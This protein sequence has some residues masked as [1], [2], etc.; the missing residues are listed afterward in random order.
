MQLLKENKY[1]F[2]M[3]ILLPLFFFCLDNVFIVWMR[4]F[5]ESK[6]SLQLLLESID[7][8]INVISHGVSLIIIACILYVVGK[9]SNKRLYEAGKMLGI[10][11]LTAG[12]VTQILKHLLGRARPRVTE[13]LLFI[14]PTLKSGY[15][16]FPSGHTAVAFCFAYILSAHFPRYR[17][18]F[19]IIA[20]IAGFERAE[21][22][23]HFL[24][25]VLAGALIG[26]IAGKIL[27]KI[28]QKKQFTAN[29]ESVAFPHAETTVNSNE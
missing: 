3:A 1:L 12:I 20:L 19:Y 10:G 6:S 8:L 29:S 9:V 25:D 5:E 7:P 15:D 27:M 22:F 16:S 11:F 2:S 14:G 28:F 18:I 23:H 26:L 17:R 21:D 4:D 24:S 13:E